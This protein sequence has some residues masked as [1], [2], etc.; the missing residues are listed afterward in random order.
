MKKSPERH[1]VELC[2]R[3]MD[4]MAETRS[5]ASSLVHQQSIIESVIESSNRANMDL[6]KRL[7]SIDAKVSELEKLLVENKDSKKEVIN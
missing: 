7:Q 4:L 6:A 2:V 5:L 3:V 1:Y